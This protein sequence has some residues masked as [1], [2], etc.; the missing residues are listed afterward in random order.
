MR[1]CVIHWSLTWTAGS[2]CMWSFCWCICTR[3]L[4]VYNLICRAFVVCYFYLNIVYLFPPNLLFHLTY[5]VCVCVC[6]CAC[7]RIFVCLLMHCIIVVFRLRCPN[8]DVVHAHT[9]IHYCPSRHMRL[10][11]F[12]NFYILYT[13]ISFYTLQSPLKKSFHWKPPWVVQTTAS[14]HP[15]TN[16]HKQPFI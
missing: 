4:S 13:W 9:H 2:L 14:P 3:G 8:M 5:V 15:S 6:V 1:V 12:Y 16:P 10:G 7:A 11:F